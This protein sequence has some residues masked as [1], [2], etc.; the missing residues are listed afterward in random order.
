MSSSSKWT[1]PSRLRANFS[2]ALST[3]Q[4]ASS[5]SIW[6]RLAGLSRTQR[7]STLPTSYWRC[8]TCT[9]WTSFTGSKWNAFKLACLTLYN[10]KLET[11]E[12]PRRQ[13]WLHKTDRLWSLKDG[14]CGSSW[15]QVT[16]WYC[17]IPLTW[18]A[19]KIGSRQGYRLVVFWSHYLWDACWP[20]SLLL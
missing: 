4:V 3:V 12:R 2:S 9:R 11:R 1:T 8:S 15:G 5:S 17:W 14:N 16:L 13:S 10:F 6:V 20:A 7:S 18:N 19:L